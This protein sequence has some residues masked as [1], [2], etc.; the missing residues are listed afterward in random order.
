MKK[1]LITFF[2]VLALVILPRISF[3]ATV[4]LPGDLVIITANA[5]G[6]YPS[7]NGFDFVSRVDID[8][9]TVI[10]FTDKGW[11]GSLG[12]PFWRS[13][14]SEGVV[15]FTA[16]SAITAGT[17]V[18]FDDSLIAGAPG[19][20]DMFSIDGATGALGVASG[21]NTM[22]FATSGDNL[23]VFQ[24][25]AA[26]PLFIYGVGWAGATTWTSSVPPSSNNSWVP[27]PLSLGT[28]A[29]SLGS[30]DNFQYSCIEAGF[31]SSTLL[32]SLANSSNWVNNTTP[33][34]ASACTFDVTQPTVTINQSGGQAD[35]TNNSALSF[36]AIFSEAINPATL[37]ASDIVLS[38]TG[39]G[40]VGTPTTTDNITWTI[41][42]TTTGNGT[43]IVSLAANMVT[44]VNGNPNLV[45]T[46]TDN[47]VTYD[48]TTPTISEVTAVTT[49]TNDTTPNYTFTTN[50]AGTITYGGSCSSATTTATAGSNTI[51]LNALANG[52][53]V[54]CTITVT[55]AAGNISNT[56]TLSSFTI[57]ATAPI[58]V[59]STTAP[60]TVT[61]LFTVTITPNES[62]SELTLSDISVTNG[63]ASNIV[64]SGSGPYTVDITPIASGPLTVS[65]P[66]GISPTGV[67]DSI[68]NR[69]DTNSNIITRTVTFIPSVPT[70]TITPTSA[71]AGTASGT[72]EA[73]ATV[74]L[75]SSALTP[76][77]TTVVCA[78]GGTYTTPITL[79]ANPAV[80]TIIQTNAGG[81][82]PSVTGNFNYI[83]PSVSSGGGVQYCS[84]TITTFCTPR[85][86]TTTSSPVITS[87]TPILGNPG[88]CSSDLLITQNMKM[89]ARNGRINNYSRVTIA[90]KEIL[91]EV[92][93]LQTHMNRLGFNSGPVDGI[94][95]P[96]TDGAIK[97]MQKFLGTD[98]DGLVGPITR[99]LINNSCGK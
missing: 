78:I 62:I 56:L 52:T 46:S 19:T 50:E 68:G 20:W 81:A 73:G 87:T 33:Y 23:L 88:Q 66:F 38:G 40:T 80:I 16:P 26:V 77:P 15:R 21:S 85:P 71:T 69:Q 53:Y 13:G 82:S 58:I 18:H 35:P 96:I 97:R 83:A 49:P 9:G 22:D 57:D 10:Y 28:T 59:L 98:Q 36:T 42:V 6:T 8:A 39:A 5:T 41:P 24:G 76:N 74:T 29:I 27:S 17:I 7:T 75:T 31:F 60:A 94:L 48:T 93:I 25:T 12:V 1:I 34:G 51:T 47:T 84:T 37:T 55:D 92:K 72:C 64:G 30:P 32:G 14:L 79:S 70:V 61:G 95:G 43:I 67:I 86:N 2:A 44:D 54:A 89:G 65:I 4:L 63:T 11:D 3:A 91:R 90:N 45:A 99:S